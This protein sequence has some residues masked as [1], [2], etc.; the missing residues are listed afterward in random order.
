MDNLTL[1]SLGDKIM[2]PRIQETLEH[3]VC[4][5]IADIYMK[6]SSRLLSNTG[7]LTG[8]STQLAIIE[9]GMWRQAMF[10]RSNFCVLLGIC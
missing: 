8:D 2:V 10:G 6:S 9:A 7:T 5:S 4:I 3:R 1:R